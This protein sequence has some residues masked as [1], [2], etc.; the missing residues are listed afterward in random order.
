ME[1]PLKRSNEIKILQRKIVPIL[2]RN[3]I[4]KAGIFGSYA[5]GDAKKGSDVDVVIEFNGSLLKLVMIEREIKENL[6]L[7]IDLLTYKGLHPL[8]KDRILQDEVRIL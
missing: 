7:H 5:R 1:K 6:G 3:N 8:L 4:A 2:K